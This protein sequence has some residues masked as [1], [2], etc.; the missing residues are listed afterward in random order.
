VLVL[1]AVK[2]AR[3]VSPT[4]ILKFLYEVCVSRLLRWCFNGAK[5]V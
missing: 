2:K 3:A 5:M 4:M 1:V